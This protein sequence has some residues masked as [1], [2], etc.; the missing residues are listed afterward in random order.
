[1][2]VLL[3]NPRREIQVDG[4]LTVGTLLGRLEFHREAVLVVRGGTLVPGDAVLADDDVVEI[5]PVIS[6]GAT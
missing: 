2:R 3:R 1:M 5:R 4:P 6:G